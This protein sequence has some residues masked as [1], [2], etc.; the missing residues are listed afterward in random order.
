VV[1]VGTDSTPRPVETNASGTLSAAYRASLFTFVSLIYRL[2]VTHFFFG[3]GTFFLRFR[4]VFAG[5]VG[6]QR[7]AKFRS[8]IVQFSAQ[9]AR[10]QAT[11]RAG[12]PQ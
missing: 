12:T 7:Y 6:F 10:P 2:Y 1:A 4:F 3:D 9:K 11:A 8:P 5:L